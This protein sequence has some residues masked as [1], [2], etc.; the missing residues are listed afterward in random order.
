MGT[1]THAYLASVIGTVVV[2]ICQKCGDEQRQA[3]ERPPSTKR[4]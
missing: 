3:I 1:C 2:L 4:G